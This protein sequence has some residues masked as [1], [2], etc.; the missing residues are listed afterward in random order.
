ME[1][2]KPIAYAQMDIG[3]TNLALDNT[4][5]GYPT[6]ILSRDCV[7]SDTMNDVSRICYEDGEIIPNPDNY[8][9]D[10]CYGC[11]FVHICRKLKGD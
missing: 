7:R 6:L 9:H 2:T 10:E 1:N 8:D 5:C 3:N 4:G 11:L